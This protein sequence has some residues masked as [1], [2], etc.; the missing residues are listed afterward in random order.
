MKVHPISVLQSEF[1]SSSAKSSSEVLPACRE[2]GIGFVPYSPLG[3]RFITGQVKR[4]EE[5]AADNDNR[6]GIPR[7]QGENFERN[8]ERVEA[9]KALAAKKGLTPGQL[10]LAWLLTAARHRSDTR[11]Q[12]AE[13]PGQ[14]AAAG[15][16][17]LDAR[18]P[19]VPGRALPPVAGTLFRTGDED[20]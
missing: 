10:A 14:N 9:V 5:Y 6:K 11:H 7:F 20:D 15:R 13:V 1:R 19:E 16:C 2:L 12:A 3:R 18:G 4:A 17:R 8:M